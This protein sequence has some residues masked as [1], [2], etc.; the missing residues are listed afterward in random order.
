MD[1]LSKNLF[2]VAASVAKGVAVSMTHDKCSVSVNGKIVAICSKIANL[3]YLG[4]QA[5]A[6]FVSEE[7]QRRRMGHASSMLWSNCEVC[8]V[9]KQPRKSFPKMSSENNYEE[10]IQ[11]DVMGPNEP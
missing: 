8:Q 1:G 9:S 2:S 4:V 11:S 6:T 3:Y 5:H 10:L 7:L